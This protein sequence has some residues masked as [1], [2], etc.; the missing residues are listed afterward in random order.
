MKVLRNSK[1]R[2]ILFSLFIIFILIL[3]YTKNCFHTKID[4]FENNNVRSS[5]R[6]V[7]FEKNCPIY[8][9][10]DT[11]LLNEVKTIVQKSP[12]Q[13]P[14]DG[15]SNL[16]GL[17]STVIIKPST[18]SY[19]NDEL[20]KLHISGEY[21]LNGDN[22]LIISMGYT[23]IYVQTIKNNIVTEKNLGSYKNLQCFEKI[24]TLIDNKTN[25]SIPK[26][27]T[28][29]MQTA[30]FNQSI[31][32]IHDEKIFD[33]IHNISKNDLLSYNTQDEPLSTI[34][35]HR[36]FLNSESDTTLKVEFFEKQGLLKIYH[37]HKQSI[38]ITTTTAIGY[39]KNDEYWQMFFDMFGA[40]L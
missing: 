18:E 24:Y 15:V 3:L 21:V 13:Q 39:V 33:K 40:K 23:T 7:S 5:I 10:N 29:E 22:E 26:S 9:I 20:Y 16:A 1:S 8:E 27:S 4:Q 6:E 34:F 12:D 35:I 31:F 32:T 25:S 38:S 11:Q 37:M 19:E 14:G 17:W 2:V 30:P 36:N 28:S